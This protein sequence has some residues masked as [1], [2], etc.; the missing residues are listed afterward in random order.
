MRKILFVSGTA[1]LLIGC[2]THPVD[3]K[4]TMKPPVYVDQTP[5]RVND[6]PQ[7]NPGSLFGQGDNPLFSDLKAMHV[8]DIVTVTISE[9]IAQSSSAAKSLSKSSKDSLGGGLVTNNGS[10]STLKKVTDTINGVANI[11]FSTDSSNSF[12]GSGSNTRDE[13]FTTTI[14]ARIIKILNNGN[15]FIEGSREL[16]LNGEKQIIQIS[17][18][19]RPYDIDQANT[20]DSKYIADAKILYKTQGD[21]DR[22]TTKPWGTKFLESIWPF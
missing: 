20:I 22:S 3:P 9:N 5:S 12:S 19:I 16:L 4:I 1:L 21:M 6:A 8:N 7:S 15:Y 17:G 18:V 10:N 13:T 14:S 11:G 2:S